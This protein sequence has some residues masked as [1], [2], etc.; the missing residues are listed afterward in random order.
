MCRFHLKT[1]TF[2]LCPLRVGQENELEGMPLLPSPVTLFQLFIR[3]SDIEL[4]SDGIFPILPRRHLS[5]LIVLWTPKLF[6]GLDSV[7]RGMQDKQDHRLPLQHSSTLQ[8]LYTDDVAG[9]LLAPVCGLLSMSLI[10]LSFQYNYE[11]EKLHRETREGPLVPHLPP[12]TRIL[13]LS[14]VAAPP[15]SA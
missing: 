4:Q 1:C 5:T 9:E 7:L 8:S 14:Y 15:G 12:G 10:M 2:D 13:Q 6:I 3:Q 11:L